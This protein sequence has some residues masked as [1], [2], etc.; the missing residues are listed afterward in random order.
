M[1]T[2]KVLTGDQAMHAVHHGELPPEVTASGD[3][4]V[5]VMT[6]DWCPQW[7]DMKRW[8]YSVDA[9][10]D[11]VVYELEY[12][13]APFFDEFRQFK[14]AVWKN[15]RVPYLRYYRNGALFM[16]TDYVSKDEFIRSVTLA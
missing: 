12:N 4:V 5:V 11:L 8:I 16:E 3:R 15:D 14:E 6:Q 10:Y 9:G 13:R 1:V 7:A 2:R